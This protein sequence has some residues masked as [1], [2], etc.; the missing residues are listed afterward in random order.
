MNAQIPLSPAIN[1][2]VVLELTWLSYAAAE[3]GNAAPPRIMPM[4][5]FTRHM[6]HIDIR[7]A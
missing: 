5:Q 2:P 1:K 6:W 3:Q 7:S 4:G